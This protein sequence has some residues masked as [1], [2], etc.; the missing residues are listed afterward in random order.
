MRGLA[1]SYLA[2]SSLAWSFT[3]ACSSPKPPEAKAPTPKAEE[4]APDPRYL[5]LPTPGEAPR[6]APPAANKVTLKNGLSIWQMNHGATPLVSIHLMLPGGS[7]LDPKNKAGLTLLTADMLDEGAGKYGALELSDRLGELATDYRSSA[8]VDYVL[9]SMEGLSENLEES[10]K[11]LADIVMRP[12]LTKAEFDRRKQHHLAVALSN[13]DDQGEARQKALSRVLFG[14]NYAGL[15]PSGTQKTLEAI[16]WQD[17]KNQAR[18]LSV[19]EGAHIVIAGM[20]DEATALSAVERAF[21]SWKG[22][23]K[24]AK[25]EVAEAPKGRRAYVVDF[26]GA[27]QSSLAIAT[28]AGSYSDPNQYA[29]DVMSQK[30]GESF[31]GR[32]NMNLREAKGYTYGAF[33]QF[34]RYQDSGYFWVASNVKSENTGDSIKEVFQEFADLCASRPLTEEERNESVDGLLLGYPMTFDQVSSLGYRLVSLPVRG[35]SVDYWTTWPDE[36]RKVTTARTNEAAAPYCDPERYSVIVAGDKKTV[37]PQLEK[38]GIPI[39]MLD[40]DGLTAPAATAPAATAPTA[41][42]VVG[43]KN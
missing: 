8:G 11:L 35:R 23:R 18:A 9:L 16:T 3:L 43:K 39:T 1:Y 34:R 42:A 15:P 7:A 12:K 27:A 31:T 20:V 25:L 41:G 10:L 2:L 4:P 33:S 38:L 28:R 37:V 32:I 22:K 14:E 29:E 40:R 21:G 26:P 6:W 19:P 17:V 24:A 36:I 30:V 13:Q 5:A